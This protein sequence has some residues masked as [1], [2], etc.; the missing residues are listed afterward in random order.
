[1]LQELK[2]NHRQI[3][4]LAFQGRTPVEISTVTG[5]SVRSIR[6]ILNDPMCKA[7]INK[8]EDSVDDCVID[9]RKRLVKLN[10]KALT[11]VEECMDQ[12]LSP[13]VKLSAAKDVLDR[14]GYVPVQKVDHSHL[15]LTLEELEGIKQRAK[16]SNAQIVFDPKESPAESAITS[17]P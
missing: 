10:D 17:Q 3:A 2:T 1:M 4:R 16:R 5:M 15:H 9:V 14:N 12:D 13:S 7:A 11:S 6:G 8:M